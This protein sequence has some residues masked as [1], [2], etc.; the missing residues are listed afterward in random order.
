MKVLKLSVH[1]IHSLEPV[2][3]L[4][5]T[6][7]DFTGLFN[8]NKSADGQ[9]ISNVTEVIIDEVFLLSVECLLLFRIGKNIIL[10]S[11]D[12]TMAVEIKF[13]IFPP[14]YGYKVPSNGVAGEHGFRNSGRMCENGRFDEK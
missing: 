10:F 1:Q 2:P 7:T 5:Q 8:E 12:G 6:R 9:P 14:A 13:S 4:D 3:K 11:S